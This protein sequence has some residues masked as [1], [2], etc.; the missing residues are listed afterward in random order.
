MPKKNSPLP[1]NTLEEFSS[2]SN[3][4]HQLSIPL[5]ISIK[6]STITISSTEHS[7]KSPFNMRQR[8][9]G[10]NGNNVI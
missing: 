7:N 4:D 3:Q 5:E 1:N 2:Q 10:K 6:V 8:K 9:M